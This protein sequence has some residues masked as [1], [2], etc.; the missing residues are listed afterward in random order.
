MKIRNVVFNRETNMVVGIYKDF[1]DALYK[2]R[3]IEELSGK[4][5]ITIYPIEIS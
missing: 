2:R 3:C 5:C 4:R 1:K